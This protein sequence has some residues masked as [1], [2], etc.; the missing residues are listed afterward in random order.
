MIH[1]KYSQ[2]H[3]TVGF[4][5]TWSRFSHGPRVAYPLSL[6]SFPSDVIP[7]ALTS[8]YSFTCW[9]R[10]P[11]S[12]TGFWTTF[13][14]GAPPGYDSTRWAP[15]ILGIS[16][17][18]GSGPRPVEYVYQFRWRL[19]FFCIYFR[20]T[21]LTR[22]H[23]GFCGGWFSCSFFESKLLKLNLVFDLNFIS[24]FL[25]TNRPL[26]LGGSLV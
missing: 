7:L 23:S 12:R 26:F 2:V 18:Y 1:S 13:E 9:V 16:S 14:I 11:P 21:D 15:L 10:L 25:S 3:V 20:P 8:L 22:K 19:C 6:V 24:L 5:V 4:P 17:V